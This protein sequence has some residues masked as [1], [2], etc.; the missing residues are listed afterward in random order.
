ME[1]VQIFTLQKLSGK[2]NLRSK[3]GK[4]TRIYFV[5][6]YDKKQIKV[7]T[8]LK[9]NPKHWNGKKQKAMISVNLTEV[10]NYNNLIVNVEI[11]RIKLSFID[12][13]SYLCNNLKE[14]E[15]FKELLYKYCSDR[16]MKSKKSA[17]IIL[18]KLLDEKSMKSSSK[19]G[20]ESELNCFKQFI[21]EKKKGSIVIDWSE[22]N[23]KLLSEYK[24]YI[25]NLKTIHKITGEE[26][27]IED[28]TA[29][30][31]FKKFIT[32]LSYADERE[33]FDMS[34]SGISKLAKKKY[35]YDKVEENQIYL[36]ED[37]INRIAELN[38][39]NENEVVR[40]LFIFQLEVGQR[41]EDING[42]SFEIEHDRKEIIQRKGGKKIILPLKGRAK[43]IAEKYNCKLPKIEIAKANKLIKLIGKLADINRKN[44]GGEHRRG[45]LYVYEAEA[46]KFMSTHT[47]RRAFISNSIIEGK[48]A[49]IVKKISG[50][51]TNSAFSRY[52]RIGQ[53]EAVKAYLNQ[54][55]ENTSITNP[56]GDYV[57]NIDEAKKILLYLGVNP[58]DYIDIDDFSKLI[59]LIGR[60]EGKIIDKIGID[61]MDKVKEIFNASLSIKEKS[62]LLKE[63]VDKLNI[64]KHKES[65]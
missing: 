36:T 54:D 63:L 30:N 43:D 8:N 49:E 37:E 31:K 7:P 5:V 19:G 58:Y 4:L 40:D 42:I 9:I 10:E 11:N 16:K 45:E 1:K 48:S 41:F 38:L 57:K 14:I 29:N 53:E 25:Q 23:A 56:H 47:A 44:T 15:N 34:K 52:N 61:N 50:H 6:Y 35:R 51:R 39:T 3:K 62:G 27:Y 24:V 21:K 18:E 2:F 13:I 60:E 55:K 28:N 33:Y 64:V 20:Y 12:L 17:I 26:V 46:Y 65:F 32:L 22:I 59:A